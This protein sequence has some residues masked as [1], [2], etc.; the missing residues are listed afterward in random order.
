MA[1]RKTYYYKIYVCYGGQKGGTYI[2][3]SNKDLGD[4]E[5]AIVEESLT[6]TR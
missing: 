1:K 5:D 6:P 4:N 2:F 3:K